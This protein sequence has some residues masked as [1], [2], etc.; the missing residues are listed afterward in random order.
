MPFLVHLHGYNSSPESLKVTQ[1]AQ[2]LLAHAPDVE[3]VCPALSP[4]PLEAISQVEQIL[5]CRDER[6][7]GLVGSSMGGFL[8]TWLAEKHQLRAVLVNPAVHPHRLIQKYLGE[9]TNYHTGEKFVLEPHH[10]DEFRSLEIP[11][12]QHPKNLLVMLQTG[13]EVLDYRDAETRYQGC[14]MVVEPG[15]DHGFQNYPAH[16]PDILAF[17]QATS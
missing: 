16:L 5:A 10:V 17:L 12:L 6:P 13:D 8:A 3:L 7:I 15:G 1:T 11:V 4:F 9:N 2:W 14:P